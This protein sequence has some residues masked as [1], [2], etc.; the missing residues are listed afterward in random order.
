[1]KLKQLLKNQVEMSYAQSVKN[2]VTVNNKTKRKS[3]GWKNEG[4]AK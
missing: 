2:G 1:M 4:R 3:K